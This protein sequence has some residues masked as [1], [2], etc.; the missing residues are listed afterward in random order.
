MRAHKIP[1]RR[2]P[3]AAGD[4]R[5]QPIIAA[6]GAGQY[7]KAENLCR[8]LLK[9]APRHAE[10][11]H[12][13][14]V[15]CLQ[16][17]KL[18]QA[19][20]L[21]GQALKLRQDAGYYLNLALVLQARHAGDAAVAAA[22]GDCLRLDPGNAK[23]G[24]NLA[25]LLRRQHRHAEAEQLYRQVM[26]RHPA[27]A[28]AFKNLGSLLFDI[29]R[30]EE[31][32]QA[33]R[34]ALQLE[35]GMIDAH[36]ALGALLEKTKGL[37]EAAA[38]FSRI[39]DCTALQ[40]VR[41]NLAD[42]SGLEKIDAAALQTAGANHRFHGE[43]WS[44]LNIPALT[45]ALH[46]QA[47]HVFALKKWGT[48]LQQER[49]TP[50][51]AAAADSRLKIGYLSSDFYDHATMHLLAGVLEAH[52]PQHNDIRL[53]SY[54]P[55]RDDDFTRRIAHAAIPL[56]NIRHLPDH[57]A[58][59]LIAADGIQLLVDLKGYTTGA[60]LG[61]SALR[62]A[63]VTVSWLGYPGSLGH[64]GLADYIIGDPV[65]TPP[66]HA[67]HF[68]ETLALMPHSYQPNDRSRPI[69]ERPGRLAAG[70]P[71]QGM[72]F[73]SF[74]QVQKINPSTFGLWCRLLAAV[75]DSVL[76][77]LDPGHPVARENLCNQAVHRG[78]AAQRLVFAPRLPLEQHLGRLQLADLALDTF[79]CNSHTTASDALWA[80]VPLI[81]RSGELFASRVA[82]SLL[83]AHG[84]PELIAGNDEEFLTLAL[85]LANDPARLETLRERLQQAR[86][87]SPLFDT[88][89]FTRDLESLYAAIW[90][91]HAARSTP[92]HATAEVV[93]A[94]S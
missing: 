56:Q 44:L 92:Q 47:G 38:I 72:V 68:S 19:E 5:L 55:P 37:E 88:A 53:Y 86:L 70:L 17:G 87:A 29:F 48:E 16:L 80:G 85:A 43:P 74:N 67:G 59:S 61:I 90:R 26:A 64:A 18:E 14:G 66:A 7:A 89:R 23:A 69:G 27:Y 84:F 82:A 46:R 11:N 93:R 25:N 15:A 41:R 8:Q 83:T 60:R 54:G 6:L 76:W 33:I 21:I 79:P 63:P 30:Y 57:A 81:T 10:A 71:E 40:R 52:D 50:A 4:N 31:A 24:N 13:C 28:L 3:A 20:Q 22:Y 49:I 32:E 12:L 94:D 45:P 36:T 62:P 75:P 1:S 78:I 58:A 39:G 2:Q 73:C 34:H 65:V 42:W 35:P 51:P 91:A 77:L 9:S